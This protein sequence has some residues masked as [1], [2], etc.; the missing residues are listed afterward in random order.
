MKK[1]LLSITALTFSTILTCLILSS[2]AFADWR[3]EVER[4]EEYQNCTF[5]GQLMGC[6]YGSGSS[7]SGGVFFENGEFVLIEWIQKYFDNNSNLIEEPKDG[8][9]AWV[10]NTRRR[11]N[12]TDTVCVQFLANAALPEFKYGM[13]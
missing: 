7:S 2:P 8:Y 3:C 4:C 13:C 10:N 11:F 12:V 1:F 6:S 9:F 5:N